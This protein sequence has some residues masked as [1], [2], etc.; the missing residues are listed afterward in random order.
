MNGGERRRVRILLVYVYVH[1]R[2]AAA[3]ITQKEKESETEYASSSHKAAIAGW[4]RSRCSQ[5]APRVSAPPANQRR[6]SPLYT[7]LLFQQKRQ[8]PSFAASPARRGNG[9]S[10]A[11]HTHV[12][13]NCIVT[14]A[15]ARRHIHRRSCARVREGR[16]AAE[17]YLV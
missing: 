13:A 16:V 12:Y 9:S 10:H 11:T 5:S 4:V 1:M 17:V 6:A 3:A 14:S 15:P 8:Q 7:R 2:A